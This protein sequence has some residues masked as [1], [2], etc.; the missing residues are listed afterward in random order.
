MRTR[1]NR[2]GLLASWLVGSSARCA[3][4]ARTARAGPMPKDSC[5]WYANLHNRHY[6]IISPRTSTVQGE[7]RCDEGQHSLVCRDTIDSGELSGSTNKHRLCIP[8]H[9]P[10]HV[11]YV[12]PRV[13]PRPPSSTPVPPSST[14]ASGSGSILPCPALPQASPSPACSRTRPRGQGT[15]PIGPARGIRQVRQVSQLSQVS[16]MHG[17][18]VHRPRNP[19]RIVTAKHQSRRWSSAGHQP[20]EEPVDLR[21]AG[22]AVNSSSRLGL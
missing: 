15:V 20:I 10:N 7:D 13:P 2:A 12:H 22:D 6:K 19:F 8:L 1:T 21:T 16:L 3:L 17:H 9:A 5:E 14:R 11:E 4:S 18:G